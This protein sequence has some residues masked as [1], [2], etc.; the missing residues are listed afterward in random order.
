[1]SEDVQTLKRYAYKTFT[2]NLSDGYVLFVKTWLKIIVPITIFS[3]LSIILK[4]FLL[5]DLSWNVNLLNNQVAIIIDELLTNPETITGTEF[6]ILFQF[7]LLMIIIILLESIIGAFF[8]V[9]AMCSISNYLLKKYQGIDV[10]L[11]RE[12]KLSFNFKIFIIALL[13]GIIVPLGLI[14]FILPGL[15]LFG[16]YILSVLSYHKG[17]AE[18]PLKEARKLAK[19]SFWKIIGLFFLSSIIIWISTYFFQI[20]MD[21]IF[22]V[23][24]FTYSSWYNPMSRNYGMIILYDLIYNQLI[25]ILLNSLFICFLT[26]LYTSIKAKKAIRSEYTKPV[27]KQQLGKK[28][29]TASFETGLYCPFCGKFMNI[30]YEKCPYCNEPLNFNY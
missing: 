12:F 30:K 7:F 26:T 9:I 25:N 3:L 16:Y 10:S 15:L 27:V 29:L 28:N 5:A 13:I 17:N 6:Q 18:N 23:S 8:T 2:D 20:L 19:G 24:E 4:N 14:F 21:I 11:Y 22:P 1:M